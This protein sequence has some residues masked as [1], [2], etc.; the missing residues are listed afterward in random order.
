MIGQ[1]QIT[2]KKRQLITRYNFSN[3]GKPDTEI[4][5]DVNQEWALRGR[6]GQQTLYCLK[7]CV[8]VTQEC[9]IRDYLLE[10]GDAFLVTLPGLVMVRALTPARIGYAKDIIPGPFRGRFN[11]TVFH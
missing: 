1:H 6:R 4:D 2:A 7:G 9:D 8:W 3:I 10:E 5:L 11:Q